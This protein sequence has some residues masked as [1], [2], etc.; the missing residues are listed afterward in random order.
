MPNCCIV[1]DDMR[2]SEFEKR[3]CCKIRIGNES[4]TVLSENLRTPSDCCLNVADLDY[5]ETLNIG[6]TLQH[7]ICI[8][9][10]GFCFLCMVHTPRYF[11]LTSQFARGAESVT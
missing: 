8:A 5:S 4:G 6:V 9:R 7:Y 10:R 1:V 3:C 2:N 11:T